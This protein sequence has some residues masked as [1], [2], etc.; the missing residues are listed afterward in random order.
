MITSLA[1]RHDG[2]RCIVLYVADPSHA[3]AADVDQ[4]VADFQQQRLF[5]G[6]AVHRLL[7]AAEHV[8]CAIAAR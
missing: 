4:Y 5:I 6:G 8:Q 1:G 2:A 3:V 7:T